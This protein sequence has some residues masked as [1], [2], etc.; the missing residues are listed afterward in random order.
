MVM[1]EDGRFF[2]ETEIL[3]RMSEELVASIRREAPR[4][5]KAFASAAKIPKAARPF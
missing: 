4:I 2:V 1:P 3:T 5:Y